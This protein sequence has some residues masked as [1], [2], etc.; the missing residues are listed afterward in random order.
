MKQL[1][2]QNSHPISLFLAAENMMGEKYPDE[3][4][5]V[6]D[7]EVIAKEINS[8]IRPNKLTQ[9]NFNKL[10]AMKSLY[11]TDAVWEHWNLFLGVVQALNSL[12]LDKETLNI[13]S[14]P[15][16]FLYNA[17]EIMNLTRKQEFSIEI[18]RFCAGIFLHENVHYCVEPLG[19]AQIY[20]A[21]P[22][23]HCNNCGKDGSALPPFQFVCEDC[24]GVYN[25]DKAFNFKPQEISPETTNVE[26]TISYPIT[27]IKAR[28]DEV[29]NQLDTTEGEIHLEETEV[30]IQVGKLI[31]A[32]EYTGHQFL[33]LAPE[34]EAFNQLA[35]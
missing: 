4:W 31:L 34:V 3:D 21:Q 26:V 20:V 33:Q 23:Y 1:F 5:K 29:K 25:K 6:W 32:K 35:A 16:P 10:M 28:F 12:P 30:D 22:M 19:F 13:T 24:G 18:K 8:F 7:A 2:I 17:V 15:L 14:H 27:E 11:T 9:E